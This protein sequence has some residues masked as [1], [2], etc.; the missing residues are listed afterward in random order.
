MTIGQDIY[1]ELSGDSGL[2]TLISTRIYPNWLPQ[3]ATL[4]AVSYTQIG[5]TI[6]NSISGEL[7][8]R[9]YSIQFDVWADDYSTAQSVVAALNSAVQGASLFKPYRQSQQD[10]YE[11]NVD[12]HRVSVDYS[13][14]Q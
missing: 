13:I 8:L 2:T 9:N 3:D 14:W 1:T 6:Q 11:P 5:E 7:G 4:P 10:L 12:T